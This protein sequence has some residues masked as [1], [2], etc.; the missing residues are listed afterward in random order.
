MIS[1]TTAPQY[2]AGTSTSLGTTSKNDI[3]KD[4]FLRMLIEQLKYQDPLNPLK[5]EE[6]ASQLAQFTSVEQLTQIR[7]AVDAQTEAT[8]LAA[9]LQQT[10]LSAA[11]LGKDVLAIGDQVTLPTSG[12]GKVTVDVPG[13]GGVATLTLR[14]KEGAVVATRDLGQV[15]PGTRTLTLPADLPP[16]TWRYSVDVKEASG[17]TKAATTYTTGVV[18]SL[19]FKNGGIVLHIGD[20]EISL[21]DIVKIAPAPAGSGSGNAV[22]TAA[23]AA[24]A[25]LAGTAR[26]VGGALRLVPGIP[27]F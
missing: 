13:A 11:M 12:A 24:G 22:A 20:A 2:F 23:S 9:M 21:A 7:D 19:E 10:S 15:T 8:S 4:A 26:L 1:P 18:T 25:G 14:N 6:F 17:A 27:G 16:G 5:A 3:D